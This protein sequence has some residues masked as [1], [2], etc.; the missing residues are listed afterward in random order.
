M[1]VGK[2]RVLIVIEMPDTRRT[3]TNRWIAWRTA[4]DSLRDDVVWL[5]THDHFSSKFAM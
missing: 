1:F 4:R 3:S 2:V 5:K